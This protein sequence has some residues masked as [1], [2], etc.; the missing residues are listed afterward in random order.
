MNYRIYINLQSK[1]LR[2]PRGGGTDLVLPNQKF[3]LHP[4][5]LQWQPG[6]RGAFHP[7]SNRKA[8]AV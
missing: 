5:E 8:V 7:C 1:V 4:R 3:E 2:L 6:L